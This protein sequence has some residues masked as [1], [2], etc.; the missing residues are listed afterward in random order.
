MFNFLRESMLDFLYG[1]KVEVA[2]EDAKLWIEVD[3]ALN[4]FPVTSYPTIVITGDDCDIV[5]ELPP[6]LRWSDIKLLESGIA[7]FVIPDVVFQFFKGG[8][9][10]DEIHAYKTVVKYGMLYGKKRRLV[11]T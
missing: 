10:L 7:N 2:A 5:A 11:I 9:H 8:G 3:K 4:G 6:Q 1:E